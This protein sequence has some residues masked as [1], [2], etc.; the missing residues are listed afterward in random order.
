MVH[1]AVKIKLS[2]TIEKISWSPVKEVKLD[3]SE[4]CTSIYFKIRNF[5]S[6]IYKGGYEEDI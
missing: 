2:R 1:T 6:R 4:T 5:D 3:L